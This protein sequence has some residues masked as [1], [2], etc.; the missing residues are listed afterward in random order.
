ML[1]AF[2]LEKRIEFANRVCLCIYRSSILDY[3]KLG[4]LTYVSYEI[5]HEYPKMKG[6]LQLFKNGE[7]WRTDY[8]CDEMLGFY[9]DFIIIFEVIFSGIHLA[10]IIFNYY[11]NA[12]ASTYQQFKLTRKEQNKRRKSIEME[13]LEQFDEKLL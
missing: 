4:L 10:V 9:I 7:L 1:L 13:N 8:V 12:W 2:L 6:A 5:P 11:L 3:I